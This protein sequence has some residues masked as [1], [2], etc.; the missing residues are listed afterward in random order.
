M[1]THLQQD[2]TRHRA[3]IG[4]IVV[5]PSRRARVSRWAIRRQIGRPIVPALISA[6]RARY[7]D[8]NRRFSWNMRRMPD[9]SQALIIAPRSERTAA[10][11]FWQR[12]WT[13][14]RAAR[15]TSAMRLGPGANLDKSRQNPAPARSRTRQRRR[16][17][18]W[19]RGALPLPAQAAAGPDRRA[20]QASPA[21][22]WPSPR[23][24]TGRQNR[25]RSKPLEVVA[26]RFSS[27]H[28]DL[29]AGRG[30]REVGSERIRPP[31]PPA[32]RD[33]SRGRSFNLTRWQ[34][35]SPRGPGEFCRALIGR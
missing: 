9:E 24:E 35:P 23:H 5:A 19:P 21:R 34:G 28:P 10:D 16:C 30:Y 20:P 18:A 13:P 31:M 14:L 15:S 22:P 27:R 4:L 32:A 11:G 2:Q 3:K 17:R 8:R 7:Q 12:T 33:R 6:R 26:R 29:S 25:S 1:T